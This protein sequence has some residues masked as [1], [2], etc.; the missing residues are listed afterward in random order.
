[1][2]G[3]EGGVDR[4]DFVEASQEAQ[5]YH[6]MRSAPLGP[7]LTR[8][9]NADRIDT[10]KE[11][12]TAK[13]QLQWLMDDLDNT[14]S[15]ARGALQDG[16]KLINPSISD[17]NH[18]IIVNEIKLAAARVR[19]CIGEGKAYITKNVCGALRYLWKEC[20]FFEA[21]PYQPGKVPKAGCGA[22]FVEKSGGKLRV[23]LDGRYANVHFDPRF[24]SFS[25]FRLETLRHVMGNLGAAHDKYYALNYDLRHWFHQIPLPKIYRQYL[26]MNLTDQG[27]A[28][29]EFWLFPKSL[30]MGW[31]YAPYLAQCTTWA[32]LLTEPV[33][34]HGKRMKQSLLGNFYSLDLE[35][36]RRTQTT[37]KDARR[38]PPTWIPL[39]GGGGIFVFLDNILVLTPHETT[40][41]RWNNKIIN[42]CKRY[43][44]ILKGLDEDTYN[45]APDASAHAEKLKDC[46]VTLDK[47]RDSHFDFLGV[48]WY[49]HEKEVIIKEE[50]EPKTFKNGIKK[51]GSWSGTRRTLAGVL[52]KIM[53][54]RRVHGISYH[55]A[56]NRLESAA[57]LAVYS[58]LTPVNNVGS[59][60]DATVTI[61]PDKVPG[62]L[63]AWMRRY[64]DRKC[65]NPGFA[66]TALDRSNVMFAATDA[67]IDSSSPGMT[68]HLLYSPFDDKTQDWYRENNL[69][70]FTQ[71][72]LRT[73]KF[74]GDIA[75][76]EMLAIR[77]VVH[78][79]CATARTPPRLLL[80]GTDNMNCKHWIEKEHS[81]RPDINN[82]LSE[83]VTML[84]QANCRLYVAYIPTDENVADSPTRFKPL[85]RVRLVKTHGRL[86]GAF[87]ESTTGTWHFAGGHVGGAA[88][89]EKN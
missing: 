64:N 82:L 2:R 34:A 29:D 89:E 1:M 50:D 71:M 84:R 27:N 88:V 31:I 81:H 55:E 10:I 73:G 54:F 37:P 74:S 23:I 35:Y 79:A 72:E 28:A 36:L 59:E 19:K 80:L 85:D 22:F 3:I 12:L 39:K 42:S 60:W 68:A 67:A 75:Y 78:S 9:P 5:V 16:L 24:S 62:I 26:A 40:A 46:F 11:S 17:I 51:D 57:I 48:R 38:L 13:L 52:G 47:N 21:T 61:A 20:K 66:E 70:S 6:A 8:V 30:P 56:D 45:D 4:S 83:I 15:P 7:S 43:H 65:P 76:G 44:A 77:H 58:D 49:H 53:W 41:K 69:P 18:L 86:V 14:P 87:A 25:Y 33:D 63:S 32:L